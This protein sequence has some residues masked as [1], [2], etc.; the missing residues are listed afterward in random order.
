MKTVTLKAE[1][2]KSTGSKTAKE[3][4]KS[5]MVPCE[6]YGPNGNQHLA[7]NEIELNKLI[8]TPEVYFFELDVDG[9]KVK[10][11]LKA[12][13]FNPINDKTEHIDF[14][15]VTDGKA[16]KTVLPVRLEGTSIGVMNG[17]RLRHVL[18]KIRIQ[19][20]PSKIPDGITVDI[21][22]LKIGKSVKVQDLN[23]DGVKILEAG[24]AVVVA[25]RTARNLVEALPEEGE[26]AAEGE[27]GAA[28]PAEG[29][30]APKEEAK[31][32]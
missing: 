22:D 26:A 21:S 4:R 29:A 1:V 9:K 10:T 2:R 24:N 20:L 23:I 8:Y 28:A 18:K 27:E 7:V 11:V 17:G 19:A 31:A 12:A 16:I 13:Q 25:V 6:L 15:E 30:E 14:V 3:L 5:G 32:E